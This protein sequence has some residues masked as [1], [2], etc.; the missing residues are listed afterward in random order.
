MKRIAKRTPWPST[1]LGRWCTATVVHLRKWSAGPG[2]S[3]QISFMNG[4][5]TKVGEFATT[6]VIAWLIYR[7]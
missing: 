4:A 5:A 1:R 2:R 3:V 7:R 6:A